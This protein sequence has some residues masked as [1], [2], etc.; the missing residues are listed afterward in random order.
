MS[1]AYDLHTHTTASDGKYTPEE[2]IEQA[3]SA[4]IDVLAITD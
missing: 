1:Y 2:L 4:G 3:R